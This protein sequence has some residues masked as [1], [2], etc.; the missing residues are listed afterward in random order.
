MMLAETGT[1]RM[2]EVVEAFVDA[3]A[4][5]T[6]ERSMRSD[7]WLTHRAYEKREKDKERKAARR[8]VASG[9]RGAVV[10]EKVCP[11]CGHR[12]GVVQ[13]KRGRPRRFCSPKCRDAWTNTHRR[14]DVKTCPP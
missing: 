6:D 13:G 9:D 7:I 2:G 12:F 8:R 14:R 4:Q 10:E 5:W 11:V 1:D 3:G